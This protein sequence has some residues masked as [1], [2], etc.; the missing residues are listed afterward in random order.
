ML[1]IYW[2]ILLNGLVNSKEDSA[3]R[4]PLMMSVLFIEI[5]SV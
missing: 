4:E 1:I 3:S 5:D 2:E